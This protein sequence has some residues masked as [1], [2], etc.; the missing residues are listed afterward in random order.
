MNKALKE[1]GNNIAT[2]YRGNFTP[3][4]EADSFGL[5]IELEGLGG[6]HWTEF[7]DGLPR[8]PTWRAVEDGSLRDGVEFVSAGPRAYGNLR[9]DLDA[10]HGAFASV[11]FTPVF[12]FRT[13]L[14]VHMNACHMS[15]RDII[16]MYMLY[17]I[18]ETALM[19]MGGE[20]RQGNVH[21]LGA[22][23]AQQT[24]E[25][26]RQAL[27]ADTQPVRYN[28][29]GEQQPN[30]SFMREM[31]RVTDRGRRYAAFNFASLP[32]HGTIEFRNHRG[33]A[34]TDTVMAWV[35][36]IRQIRDYS[37]GAVQ[38]PLEIIAR[39]STLGPDTFAAEVFGEE[40]FVTQYVRKNPSCTHKGMR[41]AQELAFARKNWDVKVIKPKVTKPKPDET[42]AFLEAVQAAVPNN[43]GGW[44][45]QWAQEVLRQDQQRQQRRAGAA[46]PQFILGDDGRFIHN[47]A[48]DTWITAQQQPAQEGE[49]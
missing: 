42:E 11:D 6:V 23:L 24:V 3:P 45:A 36:T 27:T 25:D 18:F 17:T 13:S 29:F 31:Q 28:R 20:E 21:C 39:Y 49:F 16:K 33:T 12:S 7:V 47:E 34:D 2:T 48:F 15:W 40:S 44:D 9:N 41:L 32:Q 8:V 1:L 38:T 30:T 43:M 14:H 35:D 4:P 22:E 37:L 26:L 46:P 19:T 10:L 5:E